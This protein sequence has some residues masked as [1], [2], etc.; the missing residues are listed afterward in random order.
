MN[1]IYFVFIFLSRNK[2]NIVS[3]M[4]EQSIINNLSKQDL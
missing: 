4:K 3:I 2:N 1:W